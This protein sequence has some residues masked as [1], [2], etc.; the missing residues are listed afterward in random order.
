VKPTD[1][2]VRNWLSALKTRGFVVIEGNENRKIFIAWGGKKLPGGRKK[3]S[4]GADNFFR[5]NGAENLPNLLQT[6]GVANPSGGPISIMNKIIDKNITE[7][8]KSPVA[9]FVEKWFEAFQETFGDRYPMTGGKDGSAAKRLVNGTGLSPEELVAIARK[10]WAN[11][12]N[13]KCFHCKMSTS[14]AGFA[15]KFVEIKI[16][17]RGT[18]QIASAPGELEGLKVL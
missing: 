6:E 17:L 3:T 11:R 8:G 9:V 5:P 16:E 1:R 7:P 10:A 18:G 2:T 4:G 14:I 13:P 12:T 15:S